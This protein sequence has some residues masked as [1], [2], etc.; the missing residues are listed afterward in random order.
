MRYT[1][2]QRSFEENS[3]KNGIQAIKDLKHYS[4]IIIKPTEKNEIKVIMKTKHYS[5]EVLRWYSYTNHY[6]RLKEDPAKNDITHICVLKH[7]TWTSFWDEGHPN[8]EAPK[9][10]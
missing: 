7:T 1:N 6:E 2:Q 5:N 9:K 8:T 10:F 3:R 4:D